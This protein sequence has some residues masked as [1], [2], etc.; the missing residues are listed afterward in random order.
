MRTSNDTPTIPTTAAPSRRLTALPTYVFA[1]LDELKA[2]ARARGAKLIDLGI[3]NP[4][5]PTPP[6]IVQTIARAY[7][8][9]GTHGYPPFRGTPR[10]LGA[11]AG[12]MK[13]RFGVTVD[14]D[15][16]VLCTSGGKE[17]IAHLVMAFTDENSVALVPSIH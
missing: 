12:F 1:W 13:S 4:D 17:G 6:E 7:A 10:F 14:P 8:D 2:T 3:G 5:Q 9:P 16:E 15:R 11:V